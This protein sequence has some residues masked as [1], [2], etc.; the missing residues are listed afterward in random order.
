[1]AVGVAAQA[2]DAQD[3]RP[4]WDRFAVDADFARAVA[5]PDARVRLWPHGVPPRAPAVIAEL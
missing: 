2:F 1:M 5:Q 4:D 3:P